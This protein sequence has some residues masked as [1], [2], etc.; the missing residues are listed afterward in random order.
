MTAVH[1]SFKALLIGFQCRQS[2]TQPKVWFDLY[3]K[4][5]DYWADLARARRCPILGLLSE[6]CTATSKMAPISG[7]SPSFSA[8]SKE[9]VARTAPI[10]T[11]RSDKT[12]ANHW[13]PIHDEFT[14]AIASFASSPSGAR[15]LKGSSA[16]DW[17]LN[18]RKGTFL[19][20][21]SSQLLTSPENSIFNGPTACRTVSETD[22]FLSDFSGL[23]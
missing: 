16:S 8:Q 14:Q 1:S 6:G 2:T 4:G 15:L 9:A 10:C 17:L 18:Y 5:M 19:H 12:L 11:S 13:V 21:P 7:R 22:G 23:S 20:D 3:F